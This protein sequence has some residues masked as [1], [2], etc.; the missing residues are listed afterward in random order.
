MTVATISKSGRGLVRLAGDTYSFTSN[1]SIEA[2]LA[3]FTH[4]HR[5]VNGRDRV[6]VPD[7]V[8][9]V[10]RIEEIRPLPEAAAA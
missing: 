8:V 10:R 4:G 9:P 6:A 2:D 7:R 3:Y 5:L 1:Y